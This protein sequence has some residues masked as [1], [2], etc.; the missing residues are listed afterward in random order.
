[1][2]AQEPWRILVFGASGAIGA[3][4][5]DRALARGWSVQGLARKAGEPGATSRLAFDPFEGPSLDEVL[6]ADARFDAV[7][8]AQGANLTDSVSDF[9]EE[10]HLA[11]YRVNCLYVLR[12]LKSLLDGSRLRQGGARLCVISS[13]WETRARQTKLS[14]TVTKAAVG[15]LVR[16]AA[17]D[18]AADGHLI[19]GVLPGVLNTPMTYANLSPEQ[20]GRIEQATPFNRLPS[21]TTVADLVGFLASPENTSISGQSLTVDLGFTNVRLL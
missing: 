3:E 17:I 1:M 15:G 6:P 10:A 13:I 18:L 12:T 2:S 5:C 4:I 8:W 7:V 19:N 9:D 14:Y 11:L 21:V 20:L 16:S